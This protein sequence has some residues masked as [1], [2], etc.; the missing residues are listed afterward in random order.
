LS[1]MQNFNRNNIE[2][3]YTNL[4]HNTQISSRAHI[5]EISDNLLAAFT[6]PKINIL[7]SLN[8]SQHSMFFRVNKPKNNKEISYTVNLS[9]SDIYNYHRASTPPLNPLIPIIKL[10]RGDYRVDALNFIIDYTFKLKKYDVTIAFDKIIP[11]SISYFE[12]GQE[13][14]SPE[15][16]LFD[17]DKRAYLV[18]GNEISL[19]LK[20]YF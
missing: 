1:V 13:G 8:I 12:E 14:E 17:I 18:I 10:R 6:V 2:Y 4:T 7:D 11:F 5:D 20:Y 15:E 16:V 9:R 3:G 19:Y